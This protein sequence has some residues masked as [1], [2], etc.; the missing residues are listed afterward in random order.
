M[1]DD[2]TSRIDHMITE[3]RAAIQVF[4]ERSRT[5]SGA[6]CC[7]TCGRTDN[8]RNTMPHVF[9]CADCVAGEP[10]RWVSDPPR[11]GHPPVWRALPRRS[12]PTP[13]MGVMASSADFCG[14]HARTR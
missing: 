9:A 11:A 14:R 12:P 6:P 4:G 3:Y 8:I 7:C 1:T 13:H 2:I 10:A 5:D